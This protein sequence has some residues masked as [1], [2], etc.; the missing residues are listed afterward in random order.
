[1]VED[2]SGCVSGRECRCRKRMLIEKKVSFA[3]IPEE[4]SGLTVS[5][6]QIDCYSTEIF[7]NRATLAKK[8]TANFIKEFDTYKEYG[9]GLYFYSK[10]KGSGKTR[11]AISLGNALM[12]TRSVQVKFITT[13][14]LLDEITKTWNKNSEYSQSELLE[15]INNVEV[16]ILDDIGVERPKDWISEVMYSIMDNRMTRKKVTIFTSNDSIENLDH[17]DRIKSRID[18]MAVPIYL[19]DESIRSSIAKKENQEF[20]KKLFN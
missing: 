1:M 3:N 6:F 2:E 16:L 10:E 20:T 5:S 13:K 18:K 15:A 9:K 14:N 4:F 7:R 8:A 11:L 17:D 19:P 12:N